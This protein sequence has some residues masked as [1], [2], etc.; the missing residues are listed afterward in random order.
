ME[1]A[2][3][4]VDGYVQGV[5]F[6][7]WAM[8]L[9]REL[10]LV[11]YAQNLVDGRVEVSAQGSVEALGTLIRALIEQP[12]RRGRPGRVTDHTVDWVPVDSSL[13]GFGIRG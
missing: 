7:W 13:R 11:G 9:A 8:G 1:H 10:G 4:R 3:I 12:T 5:G 2:V 6:R